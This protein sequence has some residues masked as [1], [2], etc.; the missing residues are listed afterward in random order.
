MKIVLLGHDD[1]ASLYALTRLVSQRPGHDYVAFLSGE[2]ASKNS[3]PEPLR[4]LAKA[5]RAL[6]EAF[7]PRLPAALADA[8]VLPRPNSDAGLASLRDEA[9]DLVVSIRYRRILRDAAIAI[10]RHGVLN[11]HSG[12]LPDYK[13][14]M[15]T[16]WAMLH[17][18][19]DIGCT[20]HWITDSGIDTGPVV[21]IARLPATPRT[22][23]LANVLGL[24]RP[25]TS[26][27][28]NAIDQAA[29]GRPP[30][31][32]RHPAGAGRYFSEPDAP[33][34]AEWARQGLELCD[35]SESATLE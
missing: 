25:G 10:A 16:F 12:V 31:G 21:G 2:L 9:P 29:A 1:I 27:L 13:G 6:C 34:L 33:A 26:M 4:Q 30:A 22:S 32:T 19:R 5:D 8:Q 11:L 15:A 24:Y 35:G 28:A 20:L 18:E 3:L 14:V 23:Y 7:R 17:G